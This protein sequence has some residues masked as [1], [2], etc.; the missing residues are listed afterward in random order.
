MQHRPA[1]LRVLPASIRSSVASRFYYKEAAAYSALFERATLDAASGITMKL[2]PGDGVSNSIAFNGFYELALTRRLLKLASESGGLMIDVGANLGYFSLLWAAAKES[3][4]VVAFEPSPRT[5]PILKRNILENKL[6][7]RISLRTKAVS[8]TNSV[9]EFN[10]GP[11]DQLAWGGAG[12]NR[13]VEADDRCGRVH[14]IGQ[15]S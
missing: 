1:L 5:V 2:Q 4:Q 12:G 15:C 10:V 8:N 6:V 14:S 11:D 3:N 7:D 13:Y 9:V